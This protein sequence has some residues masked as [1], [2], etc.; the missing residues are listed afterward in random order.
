V[1]HRVLNF[2]GIYKGRLFQV[3]HL[4]EKAANDLVSCKYYDHDFLILLQAEPLQPRSWMV[5]RTISA[6]EHDYRRMGFYAV[7]EEP[8]VE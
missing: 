8:A 3:M 5:L 4:Q 6:Q 7:A 1:N 2:I